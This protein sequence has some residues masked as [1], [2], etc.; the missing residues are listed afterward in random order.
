[1]VARGPRVSDRRT[2]NL[3]DRVSACRIVTALALGC[4]DA[5]VAAADAGGERDSSSAP[6]D[7]GGAGDG[8]GCMPQPQSCDKPA[9]TMNRF[10]P[11][12]GCLLAPEVLADVCDTSVNRCGAS[13]GM[14]GGCAFSPDGGVF[15]ATLS[16]NDVLSANGWHF[17]LCTTCFPPSD[18]PPRDQW[19]TPAEEAMCR[20]A[21]CAPPCPGVTPPSYRP[22]ECSPDGGVDSGSD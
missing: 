18:E 1:L 14:G 20:Q 2:V 5:S 8:A 7:A 6:Q 21:T 3:V 9:P 12:R 10:D 4:N 11:T 15:A 22:A 13:T 16:D 17:A 19:A